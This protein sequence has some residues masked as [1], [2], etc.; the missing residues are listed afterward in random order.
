MSMVP[1]RVHRGVY[2]QTGKGIGS[3][4]AGLF[5]ALRPLLS[6]GAKIAVKSGK[7]VLQNKAVQQALTEAGSEALK[8]GIDLVKSQRK[9]TTK[10][11]QGS[12]PAPVLEPER[13][14]APTIAKVSPVKPLK[15]VLRRT[16]NVK[17]RAAPAKKKK[18]RAATI[19]ES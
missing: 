14:H 5:R 8:S 13:G 7:K 10:S 6:G 2:I 9:N 4:F 17:A 3:I 1:R 11:K 19:F 18:K 16:A 15:R 12:R